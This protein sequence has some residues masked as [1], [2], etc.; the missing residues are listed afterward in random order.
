MKVD[1]IREEPSKNYMFPSSRNYT[2]HI[3]LDITNCKSLNNMFYDI[4]KIV[5]ITFS[6]NFNTQNI[7]EMD[8]TFAGCTSLISFDF[9]I[10]NT[11]NLKSVNGLIHSCHYLVKEDFSNLD[12]KNLEITYKMFYYCTFLTYIN[13]SN[14]KTL[15]LTDMSGTFDGCISLT[16]ID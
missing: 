16:S 5:S 8:I 6:Q 12:L 10:L 3:L 7:E 13:F 15:N 1:G 11:Q 4:N 9:S 14:V 2:V